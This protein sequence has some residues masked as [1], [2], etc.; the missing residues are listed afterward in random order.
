MFIRTRRIKLSVEIVL[1][2]AFFA[3][4]VRIKLASS[5][6]ARLSIVLLENQCCTSVR[7]LN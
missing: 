5:Q 2:P 7:D 4:S 1:M 6:A 3:H